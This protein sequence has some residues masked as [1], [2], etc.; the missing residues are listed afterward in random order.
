MA[1]EALVDIFVL[2]WRRAPAYNYNN[3][4]VYA[5]I[6][7]IARNKAIDIVRRTSEN[8][9]IQEYNEDYEKNYIMP[10]LSSSLTPMDSKT[11][12]EL[13]ANISA[14]FNNLTDAQRYVI[15]LA[16]FDGLT[17]SEIA[18][19]L[20]IPLPTVQSKIKIALTNL[21][22]FVLKSGKKQ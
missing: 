17:E 7:S 22:E 5:W 10:A 19:R 9:V 21:N 6:I 16:Y 8:E 13:K 3:E 18:D 1:E 2:I 14:A 12:G 11:A 20:N 4:N 15:E